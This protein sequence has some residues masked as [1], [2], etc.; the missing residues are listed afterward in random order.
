MNETYT[1]DQLE[2]GTEPT[3]TTLVTIVSG[4]NIAAN[5]PLGQVTASGKFAIWNPALTNGREKAVAIAAYAVDATGGDVQAQVIKSGCFNTD[6][7]AWPGTPT[8]A[9]KL[10]AFVGTPISHQALID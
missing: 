1:V 7:I 4:Q 3:H 10:V 8:A 5:A 2:A 6:A 9:Q